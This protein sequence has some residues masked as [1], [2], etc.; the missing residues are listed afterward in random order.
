MELVTR[1]GSEVC[2]AHFFV[3][4][5]KTLLRTSVSIET[6]TRHLLRT[7]LRR[8]SFKEP[9]K[10]PSEKGAVAQP[11]WCAPYCHRISQEKQRLGT[12]FRKASPSPTPAKN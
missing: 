2:S 4:G 9:S 11:P 3:R 6:L 10:N 1:F 7:L 12:I 8:T 5:E